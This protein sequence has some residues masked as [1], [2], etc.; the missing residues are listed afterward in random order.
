[1]DWLSFHKSQAATWQMYVAQYFTGH[2]FEMRMADEEPYWRNYHLTKAI[3]YQR[4]AADAYATA[5]LHLSTA[6]DLAKLAPE[7]RS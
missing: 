6:I 5:S 1:M 2:R 7:P 3:R 4:M